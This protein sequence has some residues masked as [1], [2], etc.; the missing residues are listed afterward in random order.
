MAADTMAPA[1][2]RPLTAMML[3]VYLKCHHHPWKWILT[4]WGWVTHIWF[5]KLII[6]GSGNGFSPSRRQAIIW[7]NAGILLIGPLETNF[8][9]ILIKIHISSFKKMHL[10]M[11]SGKWWPSCPGLNMLTRSTSSMLMPWLLLLPGHQQQWHWL[12]QWN[13]NIAV[14]LEIESQQSMPF[15][16]W[17]IC[18]L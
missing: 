10:K 1:F 2:T 8:S 6:I 9:E 3:H 11:S 12:P 15:Q 7:T 13:G 5:S 14:L 17:E 4:H 18:R 16:H